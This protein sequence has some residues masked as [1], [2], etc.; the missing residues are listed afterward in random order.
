MGP[1]NYSICAHHTT[2]Q[3][4]LQTELSR[5]TADHIGTLVLLLH[6]H[7]CEKLINIVKWWLAKYTASHCIVGCGCGSTGGRVPTEDIVM[8]EAP[9]ASLQTQPQV[10]RGHL[11]SRGEG[12]VMTSL[13][14]HRWMS[15][16]I[17]NIWTGR[18]LLLVEIWMPFHNYLYRQFVLS[19]LQIIWILNVHQ[20][21]YLKTLMI[22]NKARF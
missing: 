6:L 22:H 18:L 12:R 10:W 9:A 1:D 17:R 16:N 8:T 11:D 14:W 4:Q 7:T 3:F 5:N 20:C 13:V 19:F 15:L 21:Q 2:F